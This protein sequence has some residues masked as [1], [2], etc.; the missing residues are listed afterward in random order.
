[1]VLL[2]LLLLHEL[3]L[4]YLLCPFLLCPDVVLLEVVVLQPL[5]EDLVVHL[6]LRPLRVGR[7]RSPRG[8]RWGERRR[9]VHDDLNFEAA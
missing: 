6:L 2:L 4:L 7:A 9:E 5:M 1:M 3:L 8:R